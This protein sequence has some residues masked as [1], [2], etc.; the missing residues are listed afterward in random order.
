MS[1]MGICLFMPD[2]F[3]NNKENS[4]FL[5]LRHANWNFFP[6]P[7][8]QFFW[9]LKWEAPPGKNWTSTQHA[10]LPVQ[11]TLTYLNSTHCKKPQI[12]CDLTQRL[13]LTYYLL[14]LS[15]SHLTK[16]KLWFKNKISIMKVLAYFLCLCLTFFL[17]VW[18]RF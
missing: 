2:H 5:C 12:L 11:L 3:H 14:K 1:F 18:S 10:Q 15:N 9:I 13:M 6:T 17:F 8:V 16:A 7:S 4:Y